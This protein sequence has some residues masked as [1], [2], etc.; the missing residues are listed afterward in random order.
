MIYEAG[1]IENEYHAFDELKDS[2]PYEILFL[3]AVLAPF[4][5]EL[6]FRAPLTLFKSPWR[7]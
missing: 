4:M 5:E 6:V 3:A 7:L 1:L 2:S